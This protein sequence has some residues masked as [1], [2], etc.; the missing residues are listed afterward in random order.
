MKRMGLI[1][2][3]IK[4]VFKKSFGLVS[5]VL[6][7]LGTALQFFITDPEAE[8]AAVQFVFVICA[9]CFVAANFQIYRELYYSLPTSNFKKP[10]V[11]ACISP[12]KGYEFRLFSKTL[13]DI[14]TKLKL[15]KEAQDRLTRE[16]DFV[17]QQEMTNNTQD[18]ES[19]SVATRA[20]YQ[21]INSF[22][23]DILLLKKDSEFD[24]PQPFLIFSVEIYN[25][26]PGD[27]RVVSI[28]CNTIDLKE[29]TLT[30]ERGVIVDDN[31]LPVRPP[32]IIVKE[33][34]IVSHK[35]ACKGELQT[36]TN[37]AQ[38]ADS[39]RL[40]RFDTRMRK[41]QLNIQY[42]DDLG[43]TETIQCQV[44]ISLHGLYKSYTEFWKA[45]GL[46]DFSK[47]AEAPVIKNKHI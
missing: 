45:E 42:L 16:V 33:N 7:I 28:S 20:Y 30:F 44:E 31:D 46:E 29:L 19:I 35:V 32:I 18:H 2:A 5:I 34:T 8:K 14:L 47:L 23:N 22:E 26:G 27:I 41:Y 15:I 43:V 24:F 11:S 38:L 10:K 25:Q 9:L 3:Y 39:L 1:I 21:A 36:I 4:E 6:G 17:I 13:N 40:V 37:P 12:G